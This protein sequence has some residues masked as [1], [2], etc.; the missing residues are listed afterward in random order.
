V[1]L[2]EVAAVVRVCHRLK[3]LLEKAWAWSAQVVGV[4]GEAGGHAAGEGGGGG[5]AS[6]SQ[7]WLL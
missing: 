4:I 6:T 1:E 5:G 7:L 2:K 3:E